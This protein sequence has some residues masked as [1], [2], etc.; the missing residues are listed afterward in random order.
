MKLLIL[1]GTG[2]ISSAIVK[3]G[4]A[5]GHEITIVNRGTRPS[6][7]AG[8]IYCIQADRKDPTAFA[9]KLNGVH[10]DV[11]IDMIS[12]NSDD[13]KQTV[14]LF[15]DRA[16][17][18]IF[19]SSSAAYQR[20]YRSLPLQE[21]QE[22]LTTSQ[23]FPYGFYK[24]EMERYLQTEMAQGNIPITII[25]P[26]LTFGIGAANIGVLRQNFN[27]AARIRKHLPLVMIGEGTIPWSFTFSDD[28]A[29]GFLLCCKNPKAYGQAFH[30][31][32]TQSV[33]W[34]D[35]YRS[36]GELIGITP[37]FRYISSQALHY[38]CPD[39]F[40]HFW[41]EKRYPSVFSVDKFR[42]AAPSYAPSISLK[43]GMASI[44]EWWDSGAGSVDEEKWRLEDALCRCAEDFQN[45]L[46]SVFFPGQS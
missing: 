33:L 19:T 7:Y 2:V 12:F 44:L 28:L 43:D 35:L 30:I 38:A 26:S 40:A 15:R 41:Y 20:P 25:R 37:E 36:I 8:Q 24:A 11:V 34:E 4:L 6:P 3:Q 32:N 27:I 13:A 39:M 42:T 10:P 9:L 17:Q 14:S 16:E 18:L 46:H 23:D 21:E 31:T 22:T 29:K 1:G 45:R 5:A